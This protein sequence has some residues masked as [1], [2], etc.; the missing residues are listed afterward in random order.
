MGKKWGTQDSLPSRARAITKRIIEQALNVE[1]PLNPQNGSYFW[2]SELIKKE[3]TSTLRRDLQQHI[4]K[5]ISAWYEKQMCKS[6]NQKV[7]IFYM[8]IMYFLYAIQFDTDMCAA[9]EES[10]LLKVEM[11][12]A[13]LV[14]LASNNIPKE[15]EEI[16][17]YLIYKKDLRII[18]K[19][20]EYVHM[21]SPEI[22]KAEEIL[23][24]YFSAVP[25]KKTKEALQKYTQAV[26]AYLVMQSI[27]K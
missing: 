17:A 9:P 14:S 2:V 27:L 23:D 10:S 13:T 21:S 8:Q 7:S 20:D 11:S 26:N 22:R 25:S 19:W 5:Q 18:M 24:K 1:N 4:S 15:I 3:P 16:L 6:R 12:Y